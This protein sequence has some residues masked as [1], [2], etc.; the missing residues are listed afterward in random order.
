MKHIK[1]ILLS[2]IISGAVGLTG[3]KSEPPKVSSFTSVEAARADFDKLVQVADRIFWRATDSCMLDSGSGMRQIPEP[4]FTEAHQ[5]K[6]VELVEVKKNGRA[7]YVGTVQIFNPETP[8]QWFKIELEEAGQGWK[9][10]DCTLIMDGHEMNY[11]EGRFLSATN[12]KPYIDES[13]NHVM[14]GAK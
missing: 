10:V 14:N 6:Q 9:G 12:L 5:C 2:L 4:E 8:T 7:Y 13:I 3:C 11:F 1:K